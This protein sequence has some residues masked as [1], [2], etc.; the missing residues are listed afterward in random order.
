[1]PSFADITRHEDAPPGEDLWVGERP[2]VTPIE[3]VDPDPSWCAQ[4]DEL[5]GR[6]RSALGERVLSL[7]H[8]GSTSVPGLPAKPVIDIDLTVVDAGDEAS[9]VPALEGVGYVLRIREPNWHQHRCL[10]ATSPG[11]NLHVWSPDCPEAIRHR[12][13][14]E[15]LTAH[16]DD[17][18]R[19]AAAKRAA[20]DATN[21]AAED[22][23]AYNQRKQ[24]VIRDI[25]DRA[26]RAHGML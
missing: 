18:G 21:A 17:R 3:V 11:S 20:A 24:A 16:P 22:L 8:V 23:M 14:R 26:F 9:Y 5:A 1:M 7:E 12:M 2:A 25:L 15:W 13:F 4:F 10:M 6:I 19:Y